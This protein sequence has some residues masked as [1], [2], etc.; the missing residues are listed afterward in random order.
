MNKTIVRNRTSVMETVIEVN[1]NQHSDNHEI[2]R[3]YINYPHPT[4][5]R[6]Q[7]IAATKL[8]STQ[9]RRCKSCSDIKNSSTKIDICMGTG[10]SRSYSSDSIA[11]SAYEPLNRRNLLVNQDIASDS[12]DYKLLDSSSSSDENEPA[13]VNKIDDECQECAI[14]NSNDNVQQLVNTSTNCDGQQNDNSCTAIPTNEYML[15]LNVNMPVRCSSDDNNYT[16][17]M[18]KVST[19]PRVRKHTSTEN[20]VRRSCKVR[21]RNTQ[22]EVGNEREIEELEKLEGLE[23]TN[24]STLNIQENNNDTTV[25]K[26]TTT[27]SDKANESPFQCTTLPKARSRM[28]ELPFFRHSLRHSIDLNSQRKCLSECDA[29]RTDTAVVNCEESTSGSAGM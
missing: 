16:S 6:L 26:G 5:H 17:D 27:E 4:L 29:L 7:S 22:T 3:K 1:R 23:N 18:R 15:Q 28:S 11:V 25:I 19:L 24:S 13:K 2:S 10:V 14:K 20:G 8:D 12:D 21:R 9:F